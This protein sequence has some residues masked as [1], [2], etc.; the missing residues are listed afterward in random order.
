MLFEDRLSQ[1]IRYAEREKS[2]LA[3]LFLD[4]DNFKTIN[5][6]LGHNIGDTYL[7]IISRRLSMICREE[8]TVARLGGDEFVILMPNMQEQKYVIDI[9]N[10][11][12]IKLGDPLSFDE[13]EIIPSVS[14]GVT[15]YPDDG[16][17]S[18]IL[19]KN[20]DMA[21]YKSKQKGRNTYSFYNQEMSI[22]FH[23]RIEMEGRLKKALINNEIRIAYQPK[24][25]CSTLLVEGFEALV[26]WD[27]PELGM[28]PPQDFIGIAEENGVI[29][30]LGDRVLDIALEDFKDFQA[31]AGR[32]LEMAVN[33][34]A[35]QFRDHRLVERIN[36]IVMKSTVSPRLVN[37]EITENIVMENSN[38]V[39]DILEHLYGLGVKISIDDFGTGY[40]SY[41]Y[42]TRFKTNCL[43][44]D[45]SFIDELTTDN[46]TEAV[47]R[48]IIDLA[49][50]LNMEVVAEGVEQE[51]QFH[52][53][54]A[55]G[56]ELI[57]GYYFSRPLF[58]E[59]MLNF[60]KGHTVNIS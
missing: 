55:A 13:H 1:Y 39:L 3:V 10:R 6:S 58:K 20:A 54:K 5:D 50:T 33:L 19:M 12:Q 46:I 37:L 27:S 41:S 14:I 17:N 34:S 60:L 11:I 48:N 23:K 44:I 40:S 36:E 15:F 25:K 59:D 49:H 52:L 8:D 28:V 24:V 53:L 9:I 16:K 35:R 26:R 29:L 43:K 21:M 31:V 42:L 57:Q 38:M 32:E 45:K 4:I 2:T 18:Q 7:Q 51:D 47:V 30:E 56:C 22:Q